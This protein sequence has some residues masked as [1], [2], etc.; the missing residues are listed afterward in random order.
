MKKDSINSL[1]EAFT[2]ATQELLRA[3]HR[4]EQARGRLRAAEERQEAE[5]KSRAEVS[6]VLGEMR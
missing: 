6:E 1:H 2:G 5:E 3:G 4:L